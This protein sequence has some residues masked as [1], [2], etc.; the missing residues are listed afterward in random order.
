MPD[1]D[2][3]RTRAPRFPETAYEFVRE[4]LALTVRRAH[5]EAAAVEPPTGRS[6]H[7]TGKQLCEGLRVL[8]CE[9]YGQLAGTVLRRWGLQS[10]ADFGV[11]V[12]AMIDRGEMRTSEHD[13]FQD[14]LGAFDFD[15]A[16]GPRGMRDRA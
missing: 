16:F 13:R 12:Y 15:E 8:A 7:V 5:G 6:R 9:R 3:I 14:F 11:I 1:W 10:T 4:G 2:Q